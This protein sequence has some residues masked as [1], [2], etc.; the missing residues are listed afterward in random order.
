MRKSLLLASLAVTAAMFLPA[1]VRAASPA[2]EYAGKVLIDVSKHGEAWYVNPQ[3][4]MRVYLGRPQEALD[5]LAARAVRVNFGQIAR[6]AEEAGGGANDEAYA[7]DRAGYVLQPDDL[8]G[9]AWYVNPVLKTR[10]RLA[11]SDDAWQVMR[12]G[13]PVT[14]AQLKGIGIETEIV[15]PPVGSHTVKSVDTASTLTLDDGSK[16]RLISVDVPAN[17]DLQQAAMTRISELTAGK[18]VT[19]ESDVKDEA[20]DGAKWRFVQAAGVNVNYD[21]VRNGLAF[22]NVEY[23]NF[24]YGEMMIVGGLD[25]MQQKRGMWNK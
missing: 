6:I 7:A 22:H 21:L 2:D 12:T 5:R 14:S 25:A 18:T 24:K 13:I 11:T 3:S 19:V 10:M 23:P 17:P 4:R 8:I 9:A 1:A 20:A 16:V 15:L